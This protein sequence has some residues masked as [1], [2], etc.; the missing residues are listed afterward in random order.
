MSQWV[1]HISGQGEK[2]EVDESMP[3]WMSAPYTV[4]PEEWFVKS[5]ISS[6]GGHLLP[7]S[8]YR[9]CDPPEV[10]ED[11]TEKCTFDASC[12]L[13]DDGFGMD[14]KRYRL[15]KVQLATPLSNE[16]GLYRN[17]WAFIVEKQK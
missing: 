3:K 11:V 7:K 12:G 17:Q 2:W 6:V 4:Q 13:T 16:V 9:L 5:N 14:Y 1:Q 15:R 10:W 8:E